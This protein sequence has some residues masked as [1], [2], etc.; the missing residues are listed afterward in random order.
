MLG[1]TTQ[2]AMKRA[3]L[4]EDKGYTYAYDRLG[5]DARTEADAALYHLS[6][7]RAIVRSQPFGGEGLSG[8]GPMGGGPNFMA[9]FCAPDR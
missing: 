1:E 2:S 7:S 4:M 6:F 3:K 9:R 8:T 5:E